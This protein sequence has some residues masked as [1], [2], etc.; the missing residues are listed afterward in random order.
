MV[1]VFPEHSGWAQCLRRWLPLLAA[2]AWFLAAPASAQEINPPFGLRWGEAKEQLDR[3][4]VG[5]KARVVERKEIGGRE[6]WT[7][8]GLV[9]PGLA[10][11]VFYF[12][13]TGLVEVEL[14]Y[15][16]ADWDT[17]KYDEF[18]AQVR[19]RIE[20]KFGPGQLIA[21]SKKPEGG[22]VQTIVGYKWTRN[23]TSI[24]LIYF[25]AENLTQMYRT[26]SVHYKLQ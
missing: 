2:G 12:R 18:M 9:Q 22:I 11:A 21:R 1:V 13:P 25:S 8:E 24:Q 3:L 26:V 23:E 10:R 7:V 15:Q 14:Q 5:A 17:R 6:A 19:R 16:Q 4:L 20:D